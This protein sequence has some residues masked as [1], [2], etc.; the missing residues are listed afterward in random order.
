MLPILVLALAKN[1]FPSEMRKAVL[2]QLS[3]AAAVLI[4]FSLAS[5]K[6]DDYILPALPSLA[7]VL[8]A[9]FASPAS[10]GSGWLQR[11]IEIS[12]TAIT[13][14]MAAAVIAV[15][16]WTHI[17]PSTGN[18]MNVGPDRLQLIFFVDEA[19]AMGSRFA[20]MLITLVVAA[21]IAIRA[22]LNR[23]TNL[24]GI[25]L[26]IA[27]AAAA[28]FVTSTIRLDLDR[29]RTLKYA[30]AEIAQTCDP[31]T[32]GI[33][34]EINYELSSYVGAGIP[35][36]VHEGKIDA[37]ARCLFAYDRELARLDD[38]VRARLKSVERWDLAGRDGPAALYE[39]SPPPGDLKP[40][41]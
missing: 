30:A 6:R 13:T 1:A 32:L 29:T 24:C 7:M 23:Q 27:S 20:S 15:V 35:P 10:T 2:F 11:S 37:E 39:V 34:D 22:M 28:L 17:H 5:A 4:F 36:L 16:I 25:A 38:T 26:G 31:R 41:P 3:L 33:V 40:T 18:A 12:A 8:A 14:T 19:R 21:V 9:L